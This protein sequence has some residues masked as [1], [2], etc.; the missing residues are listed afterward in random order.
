[1]FSQR[2]CVFFLQYNVIKCHLS[3]NVGDVF[4]FLY[5]YSLSLHLFVSHFCTF[6]HTREHTHTHL[7][8][9]IYI[10]YIPSFGFIIYTCIFLILYAPQFMCDCSEEL[11]CGIVVLQRRWWAIINENE[12]CRL[13]KPWNVSSNW[14][15]NGI[16][17]DVILRE[18]NKQTN[19]RKMPDT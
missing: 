15:E 5:C 13:I 8:I 11:A 7:L 2:H 19:K 17:D 18:K 3:T 16:F 4:V 14:S 12:H 1:M 10:V 9:Y 6:T